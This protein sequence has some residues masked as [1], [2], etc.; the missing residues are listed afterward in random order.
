MATLYRGSCT[1]GGFPSITST[2]GMT[3]YVTAATSVT[4][5]NANIVVYW[6]TGASAVMFSSTV[7]TSET[8]YQVTVPTGINL[9]GITVVVNSVSSIHPGSSVEVDVYDIYI[10]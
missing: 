8:L 5:G 4:L 9:S 2:S 1:W 6:G 10:Q 7:G 3:L